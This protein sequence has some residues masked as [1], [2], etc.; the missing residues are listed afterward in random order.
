[1][2]SVIIRF[3]GFDEGDLQMR[4]ARVHHLWKKRKSIAAGI[5]KDQVDAY[6]LENLIL[7]FFRLPK[8]G[9]LAWLLRR[10][11][12]DIYIVDSVYYVCEPEIVDMPFL[13]GRDYNI[14]IYDCDDF[15]FSAKGSVTDKGYIT[16][17]NYAFGIVF[18]YI[19]DEDIGHALNFYVDENKKVRLYEPQTNES[20]DEFPEDWI[21]MLVVI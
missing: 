16:R 14:D 12:V 15:S 2:D 5:A 7:D 19:S 9:F 4:F 10:L 11:I 1:M 3:R 18:V 21:P 13:S 8:S 20:F 17:K 6:T